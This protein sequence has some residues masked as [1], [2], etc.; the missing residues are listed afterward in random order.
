[1]SL[2]TYKIFWITMLMSLSIG[3]HAQ[4]IHSDC[5]CPENTMAGTHADTIFHLS[6]GKD[7]ALCGDYAYDKESDTYNEFVLSDCEAHENIGYWGAFPAL[8]LEVKQDTLAIQE[9]EWLRTGKYFKGELN[10][11]ATEN[12]V[13]KNGKWEKTRVVQ[14]E[15]SLY[16]KHQI[17]RVLKEY[18]AL[19]KASDDI[20]RTDS[21]GKILALM[22]KVFLA[23]LSGS[24]KAEE[25]FKQFPDVFVVDGAYGERYQQLK[26]LTEE[27]KIALLEGFIKRTHQDY[28]RRMKN[29]QD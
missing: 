6:N 27:Y 29:K 4:E 25:Y 10:L 5:H 14:P 28:E 24:G 22:D 11:W 8:R 2:N 18:N 23:M 21:D 9:W 19:A 13:F 17:K 15:I 26:A 20:K 3:M 12:L 1:M 7:I 16:S